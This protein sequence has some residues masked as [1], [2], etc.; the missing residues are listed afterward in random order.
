MGARGRGTRI[1][2][3]KASV[4]ANLRE[5]GTCLLSLG[6]EQGSLMLFLVVY[7]ATLDV[8]DFM[9]YMTSA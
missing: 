3:D 2:Y 5:F 9:S 8:L 6:D 4:Q 1:V 7:A